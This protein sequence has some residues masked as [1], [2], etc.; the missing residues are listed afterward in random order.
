MDSPNPLPNPANPRRSLWSRLKPAQ[1]AATP[2]LPL[3]IYDLLLILVLLAG[4]YLRL[5]GLNWGEYQYLH[6]DER[7]MVWVGSD[8]API[9]TTAAEIGVAPTEAN[10]LWR[11]DSRYAGQYAD[12]TEWGGY[13]D[14]SCSPL[15]PHNRGHTFYVYGTLPVFAARYLV[16]WIYG[17]SGFNEM[18]D[19]GRA[20]SAA[21]DLLTVLLVY[22]VGRRAYNA[23]VGLL[24]AAF[25]AFTVMQIQ[26]AHFFTT[27][28]FFN[29]F[30]L[31]AIY[32]AVRVSTETVGMPEV[33]GD[34]IGAEEIED[35][36]R[37]HRVVSIILEYARHP[38]FR[39][40][41]GFGV[42]L[43]CAMASKLSAYPVAAMLPF[44]FILGILRLPGSERNQAMWKA[45]IYLGIAALVSI[46]VFRVFQP[47]AF[48]GPGFFGLEPNPLWVGNITEQRI[49]ATG[50]VDFP[51]S[52]QWARRPVTF[53][54]QNMLLWG[55]GL[56]LGL[57]AVAGF[58]W[59][60][61]RM[62]RKGEYQR[63][64]LLWG[65]GVFYFAWQ[66]LQFNSTM[67]YQLPTYPML[68][69]FAAWAVFELVEQ[70]RSRAKRG[71][72]LKLA[73]WVAGAVALIGTAAW[74]FAF[75]RIYDRPITRVEASYWIY[76]NLPGPINL[77]IQGE[78][79]LV[80]QPIPVPYDQSIRSDLP[81]STGFTA[82][83][84]GT[85]GE[86]YLPHVVDLQAVTANTLQGT[87][88]SQLDPSILLAA[89]T[90]E[91]APNVDG[92]VTVRLDPAPYL[93]PQQTYTLSLNVSSEQELLNL[94]GELSI[95]ITGAAETVTQGVPAPADCV[96]GV[97]TPYAVSFTPLQ[98]GLVDTFSLSRVVD[99]QP[100]SGEQT[101]LISVGQAGSDPI[102]SQ[103]RLTAEFAPG[104]DG[105][106]QGY[107]LTLAEP[108]LVV[109]G[110][111]YTLAVQ[112]EGGQGALGLQGTSIA[113]E[114]DWDDGLPLRVQGYDGYGGI[115]TRGLNFNMYM[116]DNPDKLAR[117]LNIY[118][119]S[120]YIV[121]S[122][123][124]QWGTLPRLPERFPLSTLHYRY[125]L[126]CPEEK[127][128]TWC[129][130]V[131][132]PGMFQGQLGFELVQVFQSDPALGA[133]S[134]NDQ[135]AEEAFT[136]YDHPKVLVF[137][138]TGA[139]D[140]EAVSALLGQANFVETVRITPKKA[141]S[142]PANLMLPQA[143]LEEQAEG[144]SWADLFNTQ[145]LHNRFQALGVIV[146]YL[147][148]S[149]L[150][151]LTYPL[152]RLAFPGLPDHGY[153]L[154]RITGML[155]LAYLTWLAGSLD[156]PFSRLTISIVLL[157][158]ALLGAFL[159]F[160]QRAELLQELRQRR[161]YFLVI[162]GLALLFFIAFLLVR[163]G[164]P[165]LWHMWKGGEK[166]MDF[167]YFN[168][169]LRSTTFP[170]Y[171]P[172]Y[173]GGYLNY[174][175]WGFVLVG[176][177]VK[178]LGLVPSF[179]YNLILPTLFSLV[180]LGA[181]SLAFNL[182]SH[183]HKKVSSISAQ[184]STDDSSRIPDNGSL[185][186]DHS[187]QTPPKSPPPAP[188]P[189]HSYRIGLAGALGMTVLGNLGT[190]RMIVNGYVSLGLNGVAFAE[191]S[192]F[193][194]LFALLP[195]FFKVVAGGAS[196]PYGLGDWYWF[197]SRAIAGQ[198]DVEPIT[199][200]PMFT[201]LYADLHA[202]MVALPLAL[203]ALT[204]ALAVVLGRGRWSGPLAGGLAFLLGGLAIGAL[205]PTNLSD[206][207]TYLPIGLA[208][209]AY[210]WWR[211]ASLPAG[212]WLGRFSPSTRRVLIILGGALALAVLSFVLYQPYR[213]WYGQAYTKID[214]WFG[215][216]TPLGD[217]LVHWGLF[218]FVILS[219][220]FWE[221]RQWMASTPL[222]HLRKLAK[223][224][225]LI[226]TVVAGFLLLMALFAIRVEGSAS[227]PLLNK[228]PIARGAGMAIFILPLAVWAGTLL[229]RP[230]LSDA[231]RVVLFWVGTGLL[232]TLVVEL[233]V[234]RG[235]IGRMNTVFKFYLQVWAL[236]AISAA[237]ALGWLLQ[238]LK[239]WLP[240]WRRGWK[241]VLGGLVFAA[242]LFP[243]MAGMAKI[244]DRMNFYEA[245]RLPGVSANLPLTLDGMDYM[246][247]G[248]YQEG[249]VDMDLSEDY[250]AIRWM[251]EN[252]SGSPV[253]VEAN[254]RALYRWYSRFTIYT[255]LPGVVGWEWH[256]QQQRA[257]NPAEWVTRRVLE[258]DQFYQGTD[259]GAA[260]DF[261]ERY[262]VK[263][264]IVGLL[265]QATY[266]GEGLAKFPAFNGQLWQEVY[267]DGN[268]TIY[269]VIE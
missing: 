161:K 229:L 35:G 47:Y 136:V 81:F 116:D 185:I 100:S 232:I 233:F 134:I 17:H 24:A 149:L 220:M 197:P 45:F 34:G 55:A 146:W 178:L 244:K 66:S 195:G 105:R 46:L 187:A 102:T 221:T 209:L 228:L 210:A 156:I 19:V 23:K 64:I 198:G 103:A 48:K 249:L 68:A 36:Q 215:T 74:A 84:S 71:Q 1:P 51:P 40:A 205:Y 216:H 218:L 61:W 211:Y 97:N 188:F 113:T 69:I 52:L 79:E 80:N 253:I 177:P 15:N 33:K 106:G 96:L 89:F 59:A 57:L 72:W 76:Q 112:L 114:G 267:R 262:H 248:R 58:L 179:A 90:V 31:L 235:D 206:I 50:D 159:A 255:G 22:L 107:T 5:V 144:G 85:L 201:F 98:E 183:P 142:Y 88:V 192:F 91:A 265:E 266:P 129:Y 4:A 104:A 170:P 213:A 166:P 56:P 157:L 63:H 94:C 238:P 175:Y 82:I 223:Y 207:Y 226:W 67:R 93:D 176:V 243:L 196:L 193:E 8:I 245:N 25:S 95:P 3:W 181:F 86:I 189:L 13:F 49:Q 246:Q 169:V 137:R 254:S 225:S 174:Y 41:V 2:G 168:A 75:T 43:G 219:W 14:A 217:Y 53:S 214:P 231:K 162:E 111:A 30:T 259:G 260:R 87:L 28:S 241:I 78:T 132:E 151:W 200:F 77:R 37:T 124:R 171:D 126:G 227:L 224:Q 20:L 155:L 127:D 163:L 99:M 180:A 39:L 117:F 186:P 222:S 44:A 120:D 202:H 182:A 150:G 42:A 11:Q 167:S 9:G 130:R 101:L 257:L 194:K 164:N 234:V 27:D 230:G 29:M 208:A 62:L 118:N 203:L 138:K 21:V 190:L 153:P 125:L 131:A 109:A 10:S 145:A 6:P 54:A 123:N 242:A 191:A 237:A 73:A 268:T 148:I 236:F 83:A 65:W 139:Y 250:R 18:T 70:S 199:E 32:Y 147:A 239:R 152:L 122:S 110:Q 173:A 141:Q 158:L 258:V 115:F 240:G 212:R 121:M 143:D 204:W 16:E 247:F 256:Q 7:F 263:Y 154:A 264:I 135:F 12:C 60:G 38:Y 184:P 160:R 119:Q 140:P 133:L 269:E 172:W 108:A 251:Q 165:D 92:P 252:V 261:L 128:I 26:Q